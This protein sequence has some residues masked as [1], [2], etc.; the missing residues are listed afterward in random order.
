MSSNLYLVLGCNGRIDEKFITCS[1]VSNPILL[2]DE[3][4]EDY[5][6][7]I[8][9][10]KTINLFNRKIINYNFVRNVLFKMQNSFMQGHKNL[11]NAKV[12]RLIENFTIMHGPCGIY[13][14]LEF[15]EELPSLGDKSI[16]IEPSNF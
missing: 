10:L 13:L 5:D 9:Y 2:I 3:N 15:L 4:L 8:K 14:A 12:F 1:S 7:I 6:L 11:W 16:M